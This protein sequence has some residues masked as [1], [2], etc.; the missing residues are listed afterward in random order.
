MTLCGEFTLGESCDEGMLIHRSFI[1]SFIRIKITISVNL[2]D[3]FNMRVFASDGQLDLKKKGFVFLRE[4][5]P[6]LGKYWNPANLVAYQLSFEV[7][8]N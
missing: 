2:C 3:C 1:H 6:R 4:Q 7:T 5:K 8:V